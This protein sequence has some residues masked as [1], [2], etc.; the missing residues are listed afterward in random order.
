MQKI[1]LKF[2]EVVDAGQTH[3]HYLTILRHCNK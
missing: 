1:S 2:K 3:E